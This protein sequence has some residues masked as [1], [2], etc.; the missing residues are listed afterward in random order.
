MEIVGI[1]RKRGKKGDII[2]PVN[3]KLQELAHKTHELLVDGNG[4]PLRYLWCSN[5]PC[6]DR[7]TKAGAQKITNGVQ[8]FIKRILDRGG[9]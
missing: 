7:R 8:G 6:R 4:N 9:L 2:A 3:G 5:Y 1:K